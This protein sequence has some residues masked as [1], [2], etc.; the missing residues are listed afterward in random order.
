MVGLQKWTEGGVSE[1]LS[2]YPPTKRQDAEGEGIVMSFRTLKLPC[3]G[4]LPFKGI[5]A[6]D[7]Y[8]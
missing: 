2:L 7:V 3:L 1:A 5:K 6:T 4:Y 8:G